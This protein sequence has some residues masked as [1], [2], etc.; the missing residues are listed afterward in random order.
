[1]NSSFHSRNL[2]LLGFILVV[3]VVLLVLNA[4]WMSPTLDEPAHV[5][6]GIS[7]LRKG[8]FSLYRVN[9]PL[10]R[11]V[12]AIPAMLAGYE[13]DFPN[14]LND[15]VSRNEFRLGEQ[16]VSQN[17]RRVLWLVTLGRLACIPFSVLGAMTCFYWGKDLYGGGAGLLAC[18]L[19]CF[20]PLVLGHAALLTPD[21][22]AAALGTLAC[23][24]FWLWLKQPTWQRT[25]ATGLIL[26]LAELSKMTLILFYPMWPVLWIVYRWSERSTMT[27]S[28]L[29]SEAAMLIA[30]MLIGLYVINLGYLFVGSF[31]PLKDFVFRSEML[32]AMGDQFSSGN[33][34]KD[35]WLGEIP[36]PLPYDYVLGIDH[37]QH[38][39]EHFWG[40]S[41]LRGQFQQH[42]W[43]YYYLYALLVK[44][45]LGTMGLL[46]LVFDCRLRRLLAQ[47]A[48]RDEFVLLV[49]ALFIF[50]VVSSKTGFS[51]HLRYV[52]PCLPLAF[53]WIGQVA[54]AAARDSRLRGNDRIR[55]SAIV[56]SLVIGCSF[57]TLGSCFWHYP[58]T[59]SYF[60]ELAGGPRNGAEHLLNSN[61]DWGQDLMHLERW[62]CNQS[63]SEPVFLA[64]DNYYN[65]FG[66]EIPRIAPWPFRRE[67]KA[68]SDSPPTTTIPAGFYAI[69]ANQL[70]EFPWPLRDRNGSRYHLDTR[71][72]RALRA[73]EPVGRVGYSIRIYS[74]SQMK[75]AYFA[76][77]G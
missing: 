29:R 42:G 17:G 41:Y 2:Q 75:A 21:A 62:I 35:S 18:G 55:R 6:A 63:E 46:I 9:P 53:V 32:G 19:W 67:S 37:Q 10:I 64:F 69:S 11:V 60:N 71:P 59:L 4:V 54:Q 44:T 31:V 28:R 39:F 20:S 43:W 23:Y 48:F 56:K 1:M 72:L 30:R 74:A 70:Y 13:M 27:F 68:N 3:H 25:F 38:D 57:W 58:H 50:V 40:P 66:L 49:P 5:V 61:I 22:P 15:S 65:P 76:S 52:F 24:T 33:R 12:A 26:G 36:V 7:H 51:H 8:D 16:F 45:P 47:P 34:F 73:L 77:G 14:V